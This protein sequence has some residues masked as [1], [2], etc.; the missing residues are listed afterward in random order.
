ML[1]SLPSVPGR[2]RRSSVRAGE[3]AHV[4][5]RRRIPDLQASAAVARC[6]E[7]LAKARYASCGHE[8]LREQ[9]NGWDRNTIKFPSARTFKDDV[10][11]E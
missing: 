7:L 6:Q 11:L 5:Q 9:A 4:S 8:C 3:A 1:L 2:R 10:T